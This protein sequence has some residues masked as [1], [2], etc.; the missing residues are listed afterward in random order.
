MDDN[1]TNEMLDSAI[2]SKIVDLGQLEAGSEA[3]KNCAEAIAKLKEAKA[4]DDANEIDK[5]DRKRTRIWNGVLTAVK[6]VGVGI[7]VPL[8]TFIWGLNYEE[9]GAFSS[10]IFR[11]RRNKKNDI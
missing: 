10:T 7:V 9:T 5:K 6:V 3:E 11:E 2:A 1:L 8:V 4:R